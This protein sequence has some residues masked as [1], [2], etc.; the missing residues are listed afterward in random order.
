MRRSRVL[1]ATAPVAIAAMLSA[2]GSSG[3]QGGGTATVVSLARAADV[4][5]RAGGA[6]IALSGGI[7]AAGLLS[8]GLAGSG[9]FNFSGHEG[10][11]VMTLSGLPSVLGSGGRLPL[12]E[13]LK[14]GSVY[15]S[16][17]LLA[18]RLPGGT[19]WVRL[20][21]K[22]VGQGLG[23]D[24]STLAGGGLDPTQYLQELRAVGATPKPLGSE[25][26][27]GVQTTRYRVSVDVQ[28]L[29]ELQS[30]SDVAK[31]HEALSKLGVSQIPL[32]AWVDAQGRIRKVAVDVHQTVAGHAVGVRIAAEYFGFGPVP[33]VTAPPSSQVFDL[34]GQGLQGLSALGLG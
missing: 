11:L 4:T 19:Q 28:K 3:G 26:L 29:V 31:V 12:E 14:D 27:R 15:V 9:S 22:R 34:T 16:S 5:T 25:Q 2:C 20:D 24:P 33:P 17:P 23:L 18:G 30:G 7:E 32:E 8:I 6:R 1:L 21:L 13:R 10:S